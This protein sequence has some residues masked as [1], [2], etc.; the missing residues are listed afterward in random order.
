MYY[1]F[2]LGVGLILFSAN[3]KYPPI[4]YTVFWYTFASTDHRLLMHWPI[5]VLLYQHILCNEMHVCTHNGHS[6]GF[7]SYMDEKTHVGQYCIRVRSSAVAICIY[8]SLLD[9]YNCRSVWLCPHTAF[10]RISIKQYEPS[11]MKI[12]VY[13]ALIAVHFGPYS[14]FT[15]VIL[16]VLNMFDHMIYTYVSVWIASVGVLIIFW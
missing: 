14:S 3:K 6:F 15:A 12:D 2:L 9:N 11:Q 4:D 1:I 5:L 8:P 16:K 13:H 7:I 10:T